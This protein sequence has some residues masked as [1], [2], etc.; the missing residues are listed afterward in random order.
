MCVCSYADITL[1]RHCIVYTHICAGTYTHMYMYIHTHMLHV[2][3]SYHNDKILYTHTYIHVHVYVHT[4]THT[5]THTY[6]HTLTINISPRPPLMNSFRRCILKSMSSGVLTMAL[7]NCKQASCSRGLLVFLRAVRTGSNR[8]M[9]HSSALTVTASK[10][11]SCLEGI[12]SV[13]D[14]VGCYGDVVAHPSA[15]RQTAAVTLS[16]SA[17]MFS[18]KG[19]MALTKTI[20]P[21]SLCSILVRPYCR[22]TQQHSVRVQQGWPCCGA[23]ELGLLG[24]L[25]SRAGAVGATVL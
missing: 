22:G 24:P 12:V 16:T 8:L 11:R 2:C 25:F 20:S 10:T 15:T 13:N 21:C 3:C 6:T 7:M 9:P 1:T 23:Q 5:H 19:S 14:S 4:H 17:I 18:L